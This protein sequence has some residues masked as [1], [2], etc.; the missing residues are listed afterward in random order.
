MTLQ[1]NNA[2]KEQIQRAIAGYVAALPL[3]AASSLLTYAAVLTAYDEPAKY[4]SALAFAGMG[5]I[6]SLALISDATERNS[7]LVDILRK[8]ER[9]TPDADTAK[10]S[11][12]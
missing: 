7:T 12:Q 8:N 3:V 2:P 6:F 10:T 9:H 1:G 5:L 4:I 11:A